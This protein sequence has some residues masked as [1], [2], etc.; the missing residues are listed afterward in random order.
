MAD[1]LFSLL[2]GTILLE[3]KHHLVSTKP[4]HHLLIQ[5][6]TNRFVT[7]QSTKNVCMHDIHKDHITR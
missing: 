2:S 3:T 4:D 1:L 5:P 6:V 7:H